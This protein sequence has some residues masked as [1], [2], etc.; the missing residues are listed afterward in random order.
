MLP[1]PA[2][3]AGGSGSGSVGVGDGPPDGAGE[4]L[5][6]PPQA[7]VSKASRASRAIPAYRFTVIFIRALR[8][9]AWVPVRCY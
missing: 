8:W 7:V 2:T 9:P 6:P 5:E 3:G 1:S 4:E